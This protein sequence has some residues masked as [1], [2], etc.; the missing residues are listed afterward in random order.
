MHGPSVA[1]LLV[2]T[3]CGTAPDAKVFYAAA[4]SWLKDSSYYAKAIDWIIEQ[5]A[6]LPA[7]QKIRL[8]S[9]SAAPS[10][11]GSPFEKN[12]SMWDAAFARAETAGILVLDCTN[13]HGFIQRCFLDAANREISPLC[14]SD[15]QPGQKFN[16][17]NG[18]LF[19]PSGPRTMAEQYQKSRFTYQ[20]NSKGG[21][22]W[23]VPYAAGVLAM[24][25]QVNPQLQ[26]GQMKELLFKSAATGQ[27]GEKIINPQRFIAMVKT[28]KPATAGNTTDSRPPKRSSR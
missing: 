2:G 1:S 7:D 16:S 11:P 3:N 14:R 24:G 12:Q 15:I 17:K 10:G 22:S 21:Q 26:P 6:K 23:A 27:N 25:W 4:P 8:V 28:A 13:H 20:Y 18:M 19:A 9:V 5:N